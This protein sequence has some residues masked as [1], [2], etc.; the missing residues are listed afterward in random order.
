LKGHLAIW[1]C[2]L[3]LSSGIAPAVSFP[4]GNGGT[5]SAERATPDSNAFFINA[6][7][8]ANLAGVGGNFFAWGDYD[9]DGHQDLL[10]DGKRLFHNDGPPGWTFTEVTAKAGI[11]GSG[12]NTGNWADYD[13]D[14]F[15]DLFCPSG[16]WSTDYSPLWDILWHNNGDGT[17]TNV[18]E[19]AGHV[20]DTFPSVAAGWGDY[21]RDGLVDLYV[22]NYE[23]ASMNSYYPDVLWKNN[24][25]GTFTNVTVAAGVDETADPKPGRGVCWCDYNNDGWPDI[26]V[27]NYRLKANYLYQNDRDGT[28]T[29]VAA[30]RGVMGEPN[31]RPPNTYYGHSVGAAWSDMDNDGDFDLWVTNLAHKDPVRGPICDDSELYRNGGNSSN[32]DFT[33]IRDS[34]GIP[35]KRILGGEDELF[36][37]CCW[38]DY[39]NDGFEDLF[40]PQIYNDIT[41]AY[42][43]LYHNNGNNTFTDVSNQTGVRVWDTYGGCWCDYDEDGDL[44]LITGG[45]GEA[46][47]NATHEIHLYK[48]ILNDKGNSTWLQLRLLGVHSNRAAIGAR[49]IA[50]TNPMIISGMREVQGGMGPHSMQNSMAVHFGFLNNPSSMSI[51]ILWPSG[52]VQD[53][54]F[55]AGPWE[56]GLNRTVNVTEAP[57]QADLTMSATEFLP[58]SPLEGDMVHIYATVKNIGSAPSTIYTVSI[59]E[60]NTW[61]KAYDVQEALEVGQS[62]V[63][64]YLWDTTGNSGNHTIRFFTRSNVPYDFNTSND[65]LYQNIFIAGIEG[66]VPPTARLSAMPASA[67]VN[68]TVNFDGSGSFDPDGKVSEYDFNFGDGSYTGWTPYSSAQHSYQ[69]PGD[70]FASLRVQDDSGLVSNN[71]EMVRITVSLT[72]NRPPSASI[73]S[74]LPNPAVKGQAV[75]FKGEASDPDGAVVNRSWISSID[76]NLSFEDDFQTS[77]LSVGTHT[78]TF[79]SQ[80]DRGD[81]SA[82]SIRTLE[83]RVP[84]PNQVPT[85]VIESI[86]PSPAHEGETVTLTGAGMDDDGTVTEYRWSSS[87]QGL[88]GSG[89]VLKVLDLAPGVHIISLTVRDDKGA[90][91]SEATRR[92]EVL[93]REELAQTN[94]PPQASLNVAPLL[95][96]AGELV[97]LDAS[98]S[99]DP[100]GTVVQYFFDL[101]DGSQ[102]CWTVSN[103]VDHVYSTPGQYV[104]RC[105]VRDDDSAQSPWTKDIIVEVKAKKAS[106]SPTRTFIPGM[107]SIM[108]VAALVSA[109]IILRREKTGEPGHWKPLLRPLC[110]GDHGRLRNR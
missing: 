20:T 37:G 9:N 80:D 31:Y 51:K 34:S 17:F 55:Y 74:I 50:S 25:D 7:I 16:G 10:V 95:V 102:I 60:N 26:Y 92:L 86:S 67:V 108:A 79:R 94:I 21:N 99:S 15:L 72:A 68:Q 24:G 70:Y 8:D 109:G 104:V 93:E 2:I 85:A 19:K 61:N 38:G 100:D 64:D 57:T 66:G 63:F 49:V 3:L 62:R 96:R 4:I 33:N 101:G 90:W 73:I 47:I 110:L 81:W 23:N 52:T 105:R 84:V 39:D 106:P 75:A 45:K 78:I 103:A 56:N 36:V 88:L 29:D 35:T 13:N 89:R 71:T 83:I 42:S 11:G 107:E 53:L 30:A 41:Y 59:S 27:S 77:S 14:G 46:D 54:D 6:S 43:F 87:V 22:A 69:R 58:Q 82:P 65:V 48:N 28:F 40:L 1:A 5:V 12:A 76:G 44:D 98:Q 91:S 32:Y 18:T 97:H